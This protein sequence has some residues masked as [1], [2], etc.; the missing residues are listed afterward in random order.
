MMNYRITCG[1]RPYGSWGVSTHT[2]IERDRGPSRRRYKVKGDGLAP[3]P[4]PSP[5]HPP[6]LFFLPKVVKGGYHPL[7]LVSFGFQT[8]LFKYLLAVK[9]YYILCL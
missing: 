2:E 3:T 6:T 8:A 4:P 5:T 9:G 1:P 7:L